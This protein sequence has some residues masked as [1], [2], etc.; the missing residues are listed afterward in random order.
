MS[1]ILLCILLL[2][3]SVA[4][5]QGL[6]SR[7]NNQPFPFEKMTI[8]AFIPVVGLVIPYLGFLFP[9]KEGEGD[10]ADVFDHNSEDIK[11]DIR[12]ERNVEIDK[13]INLV[14]VE[15]ALLLNNNAVKRRLIMDTAKEE[16]Y[17][18]ISFLKL[19]MAD[20]DM[21]TSHYAASIVMEINRKLQTLIQ[22]SS[23]EY[24]KNKEDKE[25]L[26]RYAELVGRY[27]KSGLLDDINQ[28]RYGRLFSKLIGELILGNYYSETLFRDK[29]ETDFAI[30]D[31]SDIVFWIEKYREY[32][33]E[34]EAPH[35]LMMKYY[36]LTNN[37]QGIQSVL[38]AIS[39]SHV[40]LTRYGNEIVKFWSERQRN[41]ER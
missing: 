21:E 20:S 11:N 37:F 13:E 19:A 10:L 4:A 12:Y 15:E 17:D 25:N 41:Q 16:A 14:P 33:P 38:V 2:Q 28:S 30:R 34:S 5:L 8:T 22:K 40:N 7:S 36:Y 18:Y 26:A 27:Y 39:N 31:Y 24:E 9:K 35:L 1:E 3:L 23:A 32:Y 29:I 6:N